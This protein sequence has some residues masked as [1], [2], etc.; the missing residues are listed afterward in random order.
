M[1]TTAA[2][3]PGAPLQDDIW[4]DTTAEVT[5]VYSGTAWLTINLD[6]LAKKEDSANKSSDTN[7]ADATNT[8]F[9]TELAVKTYIDAEVAAA[10]D[11]DIT[12]VSF[13]GTNLKV[14]EG[15]TS[16]SANLSGL[17][18]S[19]WFQA[20]TTTAATSI[21]QD[22]YTMGNVGIGTNDPQ[23]S[24]HLAG[25]NSLVR[26]SR[27]SD[28][29]AMIFDRYSGT[30]NN[31]LK[32]FLFGV[33][34]S[35]TG[36]GEFFFADYNENVSGAAYTKILSF[37]DGNEAIKFNQYGAGTFTS[38]ASSYVLGVESDGDVVEV[39][40]SSY[41][42]NVYDDFDGVFT[43]LSNI[44]T[45][46]ADGDD[47]TQLTDAQVATAVNNEFPNLDADS[48]DDF[49]GDYNDLVNRPSL[50]SI[51]ENDGT[52]TTNRAITQNNFDLNFDANTLVVSGDNDRVGIGT[53]TPTD[54]LHV[55]GNLRIDGALKDKDGDVGTT[56]QV[57]S[58][59]AVGVDWVDPFE[60]ATLSGG[61]MGTIWAEENASLN[62]SR[63]SGF[64]FAFGNGAD[65][66][67][68]VVVGYESIATKLS[69][70]SST[71]A[72]GQIELYVNGSATGRTIS[73]NSE[74]SK[75]EAI[76]PL[77][78]SESDRIT[79]RTISGSN[80]NTIIMGLVLQTNGVVGP[81]GPPG[82]AGGDDQTAAEVNITDSG[83]NFISGNV[84]GALEELATVSSNNIY[85][86][87]GTISGNRN[88]TQNN[89]DLNFDANTLVISGDDNRVGIGTNSP[90][91][92]LDIESSG[93][94]L[95]IEPSATTPTG[96]QAG[97]MFMGD[98]GILYTYDGSRSKW[99]SVD[100]Q[101]VSWSRGGVI[102]NQYLAIHNSGSSENGYRMLRNATITG[103]TAQTNANGSWDLL[104]LRNNETTAT[105]WI[106]LNNEA[107]KHENNVTLDVNE[108]DYIKAYALRSNISSPIA[109]IEF[110]WRK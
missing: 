34:A 2:T 37:T 27:S 11:D 110:A 31:T 108:G 86:A 81:Q 17:R 22:I 55:A 94:P 1:V 36:I 18:D 98:D 52:L 40:I 62:T 80:G 84:E 14:D 46:L 45:G 70:S 58:S 90:D 21:N 29:A 49:S 75:I 56:G 93:V 24:L 106:T 50:S 79:F 89:F 96:T 3:A 60:G 69:F 57:L 100:R 82:D 47:D 20:N 5:K 44:P 33:N 32:S 61:G 28:T 99:L 76:T 10:K 71:V 51:Y 109:S 9:P 91:A 78:L 54:K 63:N 8:K 74:V 15:S 16:F 73:I 6:A 95:K 77:A 101:N 88:V 64:Q 83:N 67:N 39:D 26:L 19:D 72:T 105:L 66:E 65:S 23:R 25:S 7:L 38:T 30:V 92:Q 87:N 97:Q 85:N 13:D 107:G 53:A 41:D 4:F 42:A 43:S 35:A 68:G 48:T 103:I 104:I 102:S 12:G 59:T